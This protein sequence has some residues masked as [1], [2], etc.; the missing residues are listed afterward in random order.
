MPA[1]YCNWPSTPR[2]R[3]AR[4]NWPQPS[5]RPAARPG[6]RAG[7]APRR[8]RPAR[9]R[10]VL[11]RSRLGPSARAVPGPGRHPGIT[12]LSGRAV[13]LRRE[14][15]DWCAYAGDECLARAPLAI[16]ATAADIRDFPPAAELPLEAHSRAGHPPAGHPA[17]PGAAHRGLRRGL[18]RT[19]AWR[20]T[21]PRRQLRLQ[22]RRPG[23]DPR[24]T[25]G[26]PRTA[27]EISPDLLQRLGADDLPLERLEGRAAFR[28]TS[29]DYL[30]W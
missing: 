6:A 2:K 8:R 1:A 4:R 9:R 17:K 26:Q 14:G 30:P 20:R 23:A 29:P 24:R 16:L 22:E 5:R 11:S 15:D 18:R 28:C 19:A 25:P 3:N 27:A 21:H 7:R 10:P 12:L 13:R